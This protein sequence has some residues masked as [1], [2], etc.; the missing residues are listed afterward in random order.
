MNVHKLYGV[1]ASSRPLQASF[2]VVQPMI[3]VL[4]ALGGFPEPKLLILLVVS[5]V[6]GFFAIFA[7]NDLLDF[8]IDTKS[9]KSEG[10]TKSWDVDSLLVRH[11]LAQ[12]VITRAEQMLWIA[13]NIVVAGVIIYYLNF[14]A[15]LL[16]LIAITLEII[17]CRMATISEMKF[18]VSGIMVGSGALIG[19]YAV[20][21]NT[22]IAVILSLFLLFCGWE[23]SGRN[24]VNDFSDMVDDK[25]I[26]IKTI[27]TVYGTYF[28]S[29]FNFAF[30]IFTLIV[31]VVFG[32]LASMGFVYI[33]MSSLGGVYLLLLPGVSLIKNP[34]S[35]EALRYFNKGSLYPVFIFAI[36]VIDYGLMFI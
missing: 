23:I 32:V 31:N 5:C 19:W 11:P 27:P 14:I 30:V 21:A 12:G 2:S 6:T 26:G 24:I 25:K 17:Y 3:V 7:L 10:I 15:F 34:T 4:I 1:L 9:L 13:I 16:F 28:A 22:N 36:I 20:G 8:K 33:L 35:F 18:L 29:I